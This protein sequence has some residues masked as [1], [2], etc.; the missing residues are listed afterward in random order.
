MTTENKHTEGEWNVEPAFEYA[1]E[2][3]ARGVYAELPDGSR[4]MVAAV[5]ALNGIRPFWEP[6]A[7]ARL[8]AAAPKL[9]ESLALIVTGLRSGMWDVGSGEFEE[10]ELQLA[11]AA[12]LETAAGRFTCPLCGKSNFNDF[13]HRECVD[14][15]NAE[16]DR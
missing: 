8:I 10:G 2:K 5:A 14:R 13:P 1:G 3:S 6:E 12:L 9:F 16:A 11:E 7:N 15:E 4:V